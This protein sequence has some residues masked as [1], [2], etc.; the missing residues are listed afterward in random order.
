M[1]HNVLHEQLI[2]T[3]KKVETLK[4]ESALNKKHYQK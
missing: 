1:E 2:G 3:P 4:Q